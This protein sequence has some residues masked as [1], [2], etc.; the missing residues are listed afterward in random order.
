LPHKGKGMTTGQMNGFIQHLRRAVLLP[1]GAGMTDGQLLEDYISRCDEAALAALV[2]RHGP[3]VWGVCR[4]VLRNYHDAEDAFQATFLVLVRRAASIASR[5][6]VANW[7]YGV[8]HQTALKARATA[9]KKN[10]RERQVTEMPEPAGVEQEL[11]NDL[12]PLLDQ[13]LSRLPDKY[14]GVIV[15]CDLEGKTR[16]EAARQLGCAEG[17]VASRLARARIMLA[18]RLTGRG[19]ALSGGALAAVLSKNAASAGV[20]AAVVMST[21]KAANLFAAGQAVI[22][23]K[24]AALAEGV[25]KA[26]FVTK[27]K[28][29]LAVGLVVG[30]G[31]GGIGVGV[32]LSTNPV[33]V[34]PEKATDKVPAKSE[35]PVSGK[36]Q[37]N[38][39]EQPMTKEEKL[40]VLIDKV[41]AAHAGE[42]KLG[43]LKFTEKVVQTLDGN[44]TTL[45]YFVA[46]TA[47]FRVE[48]QKEGKP[49]KEISI[50]LEDGLKRWVKSADEKAVQF[51]NGREMPVDY[52]HDYVKFFGPRVVLR[53]KDTD[54]RISLL[55][56]T[57]IDDR[58]VVGVEINKDVSIFKLS[59]KLYFDEETSLLVKKEETHA[60]A[61]PSGTYIPTTLY[62]YKDYKSF[63]GIQVATKTKQSNDG[64]VILETEVADFR[65][66]DKLDAKLFEQ[67]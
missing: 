63:D 16:T 36:H 27:I 28:G 23:S 19:V 20:P 64:K 33:A 31:L 55:D 13:E 47:Q 9:A 21:I 57:K 67:P 59:L 17:T 56:D 35:P 11:S 45:E 42:E 10:M 26:M 62:F 61:S 2:R 25:V 37:K 38:K 44:V 43:K 50:L 32:G 6:L 7:L 40:R 41:L 3:M 48:S 29:M 53:L 15:L 66:A 54:Q 30:L 60:P 18:K 4:R 52:Y 51:G 12:Q 58:P 14:R 65:A 5:K 8:A 22:S 46:S 34:A 1:D 24:V 39:E 49:D